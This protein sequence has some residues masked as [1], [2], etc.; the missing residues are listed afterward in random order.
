M[1][2]GTGDQVGEGGEG[3]QG[4]ESVDVGESVEAGKGDKAEARRRQEKAGGHSLPGRPSTA[5]PC[6]ATWWPFCSALQAVRMMLVR[7]SLVGEGGA[8]AGGCGGVAVEG[9]GVNA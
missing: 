5:Q 8:V 2:G 7:T 6:N 9:G 4:D 3:G 1:W